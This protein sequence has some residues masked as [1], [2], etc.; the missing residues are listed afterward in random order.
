MSAKIFLTVKKRRKVK[1]VSEIWALYYCT[2]R[3]FRGSG[4]IESG[5][6]SITF[7]IVPGG[8]LQ[9]FFKLYQ[10]FLRKYVCKQRRMGPF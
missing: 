3:Q 6:V 7:L 4:M 2:G 5:S 9:D 10:D 8:L 1:K